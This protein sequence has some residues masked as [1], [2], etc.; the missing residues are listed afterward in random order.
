[1]SSNA[2]YLQREHIVDRDR[3]MAEQEE[4]NEAVRQQMK[5]KLKGNE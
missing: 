1:M 3:R 5:V 2:A 4:W